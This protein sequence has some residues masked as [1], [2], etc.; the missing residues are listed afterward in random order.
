[1]FNAFDEAGHKLAA[2]GAKDRKSPK[3]VANWLRKQKL[4]F[5]CDCGRHR[6]FLRY[7]ATIGGFAAG[8]R[9][10]GFPKIRNPGLKGV[11]CK[12]V[13]R[14]MTEIESSNAVLHFLEKYMEKL[15]ASADNTTRIQA[16]QSEAEEA[17]SSKSAT[18]IKTSEQ[19]KTEARKGQRA[20]CSKGGSKGGAS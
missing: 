4:S 20:P 11:A 19:R 7:V 6:Y 8:G 15:Q 18:K 16:A 12:H 5:D 2:T 14:V 3:Q 1:M 9:N 13:L 17:A 10:G